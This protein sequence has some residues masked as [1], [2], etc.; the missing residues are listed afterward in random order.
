[1]RGAQHVAI[2][3][4]AVRIDAVGCSVAEPIVPGE[5]LP[6]G[7]GEHFH[8]DSALPVRHSIGRRGLRQQQVTVLRIIVARFFGLGI[9]APVLQRQVAGAR[10]VRHRVKPTVRPHLRPRIWLVAVAAESQ[11]RHGG[12][13][14]MIFDG[15]LVVTHHEPERGGLATEVVAFEFAVHCLGTHE[16]RHPLS[17]NTS[18][19]S[20]ALIKIVLDVGDCE[21]LSTR[22]SNR[23]EGVGLYQ[24]RRSR[25]SRRS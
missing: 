7:G 9:E 13:V 24:S 8:I 4:E 10:F 1:M 21:N 20:V 15:L 25:D 17:A 12:I 22:L 5:S 11:V 6:L 23:A 19:H 14:G 3:G 16:I 2:D 18:P